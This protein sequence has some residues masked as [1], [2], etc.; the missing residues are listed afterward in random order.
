[1]QSTS[2]RIS[3]LVLPI[4]GF[5]MLL[6]ALAGPTGKLLAQVQGDATSCI[7]AVAGNYGHTNL[8]SSCRENLV[9]EYCGDGNDDDNNWSCSKNHHGQTSVNGGRPTEIPGKITGEVFFAACKSPLRPVWLVIFRPYSF[10]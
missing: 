1:M 5:A 6:T 7:S 4:F 3:S 2:R 9:V 8:V 10:V